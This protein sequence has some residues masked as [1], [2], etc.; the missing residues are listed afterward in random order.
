M[1]AETSTWVGPTATPPAGNTAIPLNVSSNN[2]DKAGGLS[3]GGPLLV[4]GALQILSGTPGVGKVLTS[5]A[6]GE[7]TWQ[8][9][10]GGGGGSPATIYVDVSGK[11]SCTASCPSGKK[12][13]G[14]GCQLPGLRGLNILISSYPTIDHTGWSCQ[15]NNGTSGANNITCTAICQ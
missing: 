7:A 13:T 2:Q 5:N 9:S 1:A 12:V 3:I 11:A 15:T 8:A 4:N 6:T 14:G 10:A